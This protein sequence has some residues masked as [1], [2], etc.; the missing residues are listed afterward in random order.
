MKERKGETIEQRL[1]Y[2]KNL[3]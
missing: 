2:T 3:W 1:K